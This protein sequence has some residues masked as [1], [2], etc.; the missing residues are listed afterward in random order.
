MNVPP[1]RWLQVWILAALQGSITLCWVIYNFYIPQFLEGLGFTAGVAMLLQLIENALA[2]VIEPIMGAASDQTRLWM[3]SRFPL[4]AAGV[5]GSAVLFVGIPWVGDW[6]EARLILPMLAVVW[7]VAMSVFRSPAM[8]LLGS[9]ASATQLPQATAILTL[10]GGLTGALSPL[11]QTAILN[12]GPTAAFLVGSIVLLVV[13]SVLR[14]VAGSLAAEPSGSLPTVISQAST[15]SPQPLALPSLAGIF[16]LGLGVALGFR[17]MVTAFPSVLI[18]LGANFSFPQIIA[19]ILFVSGL[20]AIPVGRWATQWGNST[21]LLAGLLGMGIGLLI[22]LGIPHLLVGYLLIG[23]FGLSF[24]LINTS[25]FSLSL[26]WVPP[27]RAGLG[28]GLYFGGFSG[29]MAVVNTLLVVRPE[30]PHLALVGL[31]IIGLGLA[32]LGVFLGQ[33]LSTQNHP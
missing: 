32:Q 9:Y 29:G 13:A 10:V 27:E 28:I 16:M 31:G 30:I 8:A 2:A 25:A 15:A 17:M 1:V 23:L 12:L 18:D 7:A 4:I 21:T 24:S 5:L 19:G 6:S 3:S 14:G 11:T 33:T 26:L 20:A 22:T